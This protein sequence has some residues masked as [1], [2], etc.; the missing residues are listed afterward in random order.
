VSENGVET[1]P[2]KIS[3]IKNRAIRRNVKEVKS[4]L[5]L[6]SYYRRFVAGFANIAKPLH[7]I[8]EKSNT[9]IWS[10]ECAQAFEKLKHALISYPILGYP[11][12]DSP[13]VLDTDA[14]K[15]ATDAVLSQIQDGKEVFIAYY[16]STMDKHEMNYCVT[17]KELLAVV[18]ALN[19]FH[20]YLYGQHFLLR[21]DNAAVSWMRSLKNA[22]DQVARW[23]QILGTYDFKVVHRPGHQHRNADAPSRALCKKCLKQKKNDSC[24]DDD[25]ACNP[26]NPPVSS[27]LA[28]PF[29]GPRKTEGHTPGRPGLSLLNMPLLL[30]R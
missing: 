23:L 8:A 19:A 14:S 10:E 20:H 2:D 29:F 30:L 12:A 21:T 1:D 3:A 16:S 18:N 25:N 4:S 6:C 28:S 5:G 22:T 26:V 13:F 27:I 17:H 7:K 9:F 24:D 11:N 15:H